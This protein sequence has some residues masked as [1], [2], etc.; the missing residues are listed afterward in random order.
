MGSIPSSLLA[1]LSFASGKKG[2]GGT[3]Q[4]RQKERA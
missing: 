4:A 2:E 3:W 1:V